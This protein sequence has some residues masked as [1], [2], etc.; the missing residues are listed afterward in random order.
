MKW[1]NDLHLRSKLVAGFVLVALIAGIVG[2]IGI[3]RIGVMEQ[4]G[5]DMYEHN[6]EP[7]G[8]FGN[9]AIAFQKARVNIRGMILDD[10]PA[11][12]QA[13]ATSIAKLYKEID[14]NLAV[15][16][17]TI[18]TEQGKKEL[19]ALRT[20]LANYQPVREQIINATLEGDRETALTV[21][22]S[23]GLGFEKNIDTSIKKMFDMKIATGKARSEQNSAVA[24]SA[25]IQMTV[26]AGIGF[27]L[28]V[29][30]G[31]FIAHQLT[32]PLK[33]A[34]GLAKA[35]ADGDL[36]SHLDMERGDETGQLAAAMNT[37]AER[38]NRLIAG[39]AENSTQVAAAAGQLTANAEQM[40]TGAEEVAAQTGT[41]ATASEEM[42]ATSTEIA[43][44]CT[45][46]AQEAKNASDT[47]TQGSAVI[48]ETVHEMSLIAERVRE[49]AKT[50]ESLGARSDQIGEIIG[51][52]EDIA[53]QTNLLALNAA[54]EA[55]RAGEQGR[56]FAVV[57]DEV[58]ALAERTT[59]A[60]KEIG[61]M[62]KAIQQETKGAVVSMEQGVREVERGTAEATQ[63]GEALH[64]IL[65]KISS[66]TLQV[67]QIATA[68]EQQ[69]ATT[70]EISNNIQQITTVVQDTARG[71]QETAAAS[72]Q[73]S[74]L[75]DE[76]QRLI[77]QFRLA[78]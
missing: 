12:A 11:R 10:N 40:A 38:L 43:L 59:K 16:G 28:A 57:A 75:S 56:G 21:M 64:E 48:R 20:L 68:A 49:T 45:S 7:L 13:N 8:T 53:D 35:I 6:T 9:I 34:V 78:S 24:Q 63:S 30:L 62:I 14:T 23:E 47:A 71:A 72:R 27:V 19:E 17:K 76:L 73:L 66:V 61:A 25:K 60:T 44:N 74:Q 1:L 42:A 3:S 31:F 39:V 51:T 37:M 18:E 65:D 32:A 15:F 77:G 67:N 52:I 70:S 2:I 22:R 29:L 58:R 54:I 46:A 26:F 36:T 4:A 5:I 69:T 33:Q 55:A 41:V 50:V